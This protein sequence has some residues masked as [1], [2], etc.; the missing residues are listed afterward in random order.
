VVLSKPL[1]T[2]IALAS[3]NPDA[4]AAAVRGMRCLNRGPAEEL[5]H[6]REE[7]HAVT[8]V[9][10]FGL[11]GHAFEMAQR[12]GVAFVLEHERLPMYEGVLEAARAGVRTGGDTR[13]RDHLADHVEIDADE[14]FAAVAFDPQTS[15]GLLAAVDAHS[16]AALAAVGF[17]DIG[18]VLEGEPRVALR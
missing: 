3:G 17:V 11:F 4:H 10:G 6:R 9:T 12:S 18:A 13:N 2:G 7:V 8:D 1:G 16:V 15:G 5:A 14:A